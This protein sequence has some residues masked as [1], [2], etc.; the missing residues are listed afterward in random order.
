MLTVVNLSEVS[1][2]AVPED[3]LQETLLRCIIE[4]LEK[5]RV[6]KFKSVVNNNTIIRE[7]KM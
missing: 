1:T 2:T 3:N 4:S 5:C 7:W 6:N